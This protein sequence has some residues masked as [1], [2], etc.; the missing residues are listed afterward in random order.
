MNAHAGILRRTPEA[1]QYLTVGSATA[2]ADD[3]D[4]IEIF[5]ILDLQGHPI[6]GKTLG[7]PVPRRKK[8]ADV[9]QQPA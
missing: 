3:G 7:Y 4:V 9:G 2:G 5:T 6:D 8:G 1:S